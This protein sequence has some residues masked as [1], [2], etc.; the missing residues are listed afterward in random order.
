M[1][2]IR[3]FAS[4]LIIVFTWTAGTDHS[5]WRAPNV[6]DGSGALAAGQQKQADKVWMVGFSGKTRSQN[7]FNDPIPFRKSSASHGSCFAPRRDACLTAGEPN[8]G[9]SLSY[10]SSFAGLTGYSQ[11]DVIFSVIGRS[12]QLETPKGGIR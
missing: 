11:E 5:A 12:R 4:V 7:R 3:V 6:N 9:A 10:T 8:P 2:L 1:S